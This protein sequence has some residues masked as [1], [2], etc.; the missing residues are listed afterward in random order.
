MS[1]QGRCRCASVDTDACP[2]ASIR[3]RITPIQKMLSGGRDKLRHPLPAYGWF[4]TTLSSKIAA[5]QIKRR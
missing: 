2:F 3:E 4:P 5:L 1:A